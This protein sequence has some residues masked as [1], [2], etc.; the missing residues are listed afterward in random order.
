MNS[1]FIYNSCF[2]IAMLLGP[3]QMVNLVG[4]PPTFKEM[5][6]RNAL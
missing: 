2:L 5:K 6:I 1:P 4:S 3:K